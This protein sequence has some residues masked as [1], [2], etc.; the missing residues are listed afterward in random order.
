[1]LNGT[2]LATIG[3]CRQPFF[4]VKTLY[5][6]SLYYLFTLDNEYH[7]ITYP[8]PKGLSFSM[9]DMRLDGGLG[10]IVPGQ[11]NIQVSGAEQ[12]TDV[13]TATRHKNNR[14]VWLVVR[15]YINSNEFLSYKI[16]SS[17]INMNPVVSN[18]L[19]TWVYIPG[20]GGPE[21]I[22]ISPDGTIFICVYG[23]VLELCHFS[24]ETGVI[25]PMFIFDSLQSHNSVEFSL[26]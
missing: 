9:V 17:G 5:D 8:D 24:S 13:M 1:M 21:E 2:G 15:K 7:P 18:S 16:T 22:K 6:D 25:T 10:A 20:D 12:T 14:D 11:K 26:N 23:W 3:G 4:I 19:V